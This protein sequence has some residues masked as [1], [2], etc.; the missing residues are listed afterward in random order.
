LD[1]LAIDDIASGVAHL[2]FK[3]TIAYEDI[4]GKTHR[5]RWCF[6]WVGGTL[7]TQACPEKEENDFD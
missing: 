5:T 1:Q 2:Q 6:N 7:G 4:F 3:G